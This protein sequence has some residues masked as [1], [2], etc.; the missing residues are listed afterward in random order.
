MERS[1]MSPKVSICVVTYNQERYI[2]DCLVSVLQQRFDAHIEILVGDDASTDGS[3]KVIASLAAQ[4]PDVIKHFRHE[5]NLGGCRNYQFLIERS[6][7]DYIAHL[8]GDD[9]WL[10]GKLEMQ[11]NFLAKHPECVAVY[12]NAAVLSSDKALL[13]AFSGVQ[14]EI[15]D[16]NYLL[17]RGNY[18]AHSSLMY[19]AG[20]KGSLLSITER[21]LDYRIH[22]RLAMQGKLGFVNSTLVA[23]RA[24][25]QGSVQLTESD[26][27]RKL[28]WEALA[29]VNRLEIKP[30]GLVDG[31]GNFLTRIVSAGIRTSRPRY[32]YSWIKTVH[33]ETNYRATQILLS[34]SKAA[35][36]KAG[37]F[38]QNALLRVIKKDILLI[39]F[40][41]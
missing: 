38:V 25:V 26:A 36:R 1:Q 20:L 10:P 28:F 24:G 41:R 37:R 15:Q 9:F 2:R 17:L 23:Y 12:T 4:Y 5:S 13:G 32:V 14:P 21:F 27:M 34:F 40:N 18:L 16:L 6:S 19:R 3:G 11:L 7:G 39:S 29:D 33:H 22:C 8:D 35:L 31:V 30:T